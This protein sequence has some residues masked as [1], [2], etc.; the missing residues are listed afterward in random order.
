MESGHEQKTDGFDDGNCRLSRHIYCGASI[1]PIVDRPYWGGEVTEHHRMQYQLM[2]DMAQEMTRMTE[3]MAKGELS[4]ELRK[5]MAGRMAL[6]STMMQRMSGLA[7]R[8]A[9]REPEWQ[10]QMGGMRKQM[11][12]MMRDSTMMPGAK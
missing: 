2:N 5:Q 11:D 3:Q 10:K 6:M 4:P 8:P 7:S 9:M 12:G 1:G